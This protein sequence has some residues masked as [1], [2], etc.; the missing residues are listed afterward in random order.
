V[1]VAEVEGVDGHAQRLEHG[2]GHAVHRLG[3]RMQRLGRP[4]QVLAQPAVAAPVTREDDVGAEVLM[5]L[6]AALAV[7]AVQCGVDGDAA[8]VERAAL[9]HAREL[10]ADD[11]RVCELRV[12]DPALVVPMQ[13]RAADPHGLHA[14]Q[15]LPRAGRRP[16]LVG[17]AQVAHPV[18]PRDRTHAAADRF[19]MILDMREVC[20]ARREPSLVIAHNTDNK[21]IGSGSAQ[22]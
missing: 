9:D 16:R 7:P 2:A 10:V 6:Q 14:H 19:M 15:A 21:P 17:D 4:A 13:V 8:A 1:D 20:H 12:A 3:Q 5:A 11:Q 22:E 18:Q